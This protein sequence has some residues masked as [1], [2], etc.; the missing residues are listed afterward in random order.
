MINEL[1]ENN[2]TK[3]TLR[4]VFFTIGIAI[5]F[6][7]IWINELVIVVG[8][9]LIIMTLFIKDRSIQVFNDRFEIRGKSILPILNSKESFKYRDIKKV[10]FSESYSDIFKSTLKSIV[11]DDFI[12]MGNS[13][14]NTYSKPD[15]ITIRMQDNSFRVLNRIGSKDQFISCFKSILEELNKQK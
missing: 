13:G 5:I 11:I 2:T 8:L 12:F 14:Y 15:N 3:L 10:E 9:Y 7:A 1:R 6:S 4:I